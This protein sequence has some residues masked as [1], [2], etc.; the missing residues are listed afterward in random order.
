MKKIFD[1]ILR[2]LYIKKRDP[3]A[4][5]NTNIKLMHGMNRISILLFVIALIIMITRLF[6]KHH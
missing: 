2:Y 3:D 1:Q 5:T 4:P 6:F